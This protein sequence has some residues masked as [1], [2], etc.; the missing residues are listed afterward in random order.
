MKITV[1]ENVCAK[2]RKKIRTHSQPVTPYIRDDALMNTYDLYL[3][4]SG[5]Q[6]ANPYAERE[7]QSEIFIRNT[8][9]FNLYQFYIQARAHTHTI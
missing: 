1:T 2:R 3:H 5:E 6:P 9:T 7:R 8:T 4:D